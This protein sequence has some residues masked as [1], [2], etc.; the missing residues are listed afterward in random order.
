MK[1]E[2]LAKELLKNPDFEVHFS[3]FE[4]DGSHYGAG[5]RTFK[6]KVDDIGYSSKLIKLGSEKEL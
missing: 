1:A 5:L 4:A 2:K 6:I 3:I